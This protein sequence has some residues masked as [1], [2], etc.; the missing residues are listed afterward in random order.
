[1]LNGVDVRYIN[2]KSILGNPGDSWPDS[3]W[4]LE[5]RYD[6]VEEFL[7]DVYPEG[8]PFDKFCDWVRFESSDFVA[9]FP[10]TWQAL[11]ERHLLDAETLANASR[12]DGDE[13]ALIELATEADPKLGE[14]VRQELIKWGRLD[15]SMRPRHRGQKRISESRRTRPV[16]RARRR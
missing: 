1:M 13:E 12:F 11:Y 16:R 14:E 5:H 6:E 4:I 10:S 8:M 3:L 2:W 7:E 9:E 15:E